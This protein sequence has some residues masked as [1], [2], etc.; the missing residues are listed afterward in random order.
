MKQRGVLRLKD[1]REWTWEIEG[2]WRK[3]DTSKEQVP[4]DVLIDLA[5]GTNETGYEMIQ[6][7][8]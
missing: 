2:E 4:V 8:E 3:F 1:G 7:V 5:D 6:E